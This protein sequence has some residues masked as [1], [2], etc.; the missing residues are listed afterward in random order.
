VIL[1]RFAKRNWMPGETFTAD[2]DLA[3]YGARD[4]T[5]VKAVW[6]LRDEAGKTV[7]EG[8]MNAVTARTG[9]LTRLGRCEALIPKVDRAAHWNLSLELEGTKVAN[10]WS[11]WI[12]PAAEP[13]LPEDVL[14]TDDWKV[15]RTRLEDGGK[16]L[17]LAQGAPGA[18]PTANA[19]WR[20]RFATPFWTCSAVPGLNRSC[21]LL[22]LN[23]HPAFAGFPTDYHADWQWK[24]I[25]DGASRMSFVELPKRLDPIVLV[26]DSPLFNHRQ[27]A[28]FEARYGAGRLMACSLN[29][30]GDLSRKPA[31]SCLKQSLLDYM[32]GE[33]FNPAIDLGGVDLPEKLFAVPGEGSAATGTV[34]AGVGPAGDQH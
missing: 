27:A 33:K 8:A 24:E 20:I 30:G 12:F 26:I 15:A 7:S 13:R 10:D 6:R 28:L 11:M 1:A 4:M 31:A 29:L 23:R 34:A 32:A 5:G 21:G 18:D 19:D 17:W 25:Q 16:V 9:G 14:V 2:V 3:H 22:I